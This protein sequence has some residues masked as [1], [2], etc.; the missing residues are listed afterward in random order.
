MCRLIHTKFSSTSI[1][2]NLLDIILSQVGNVLRPVRRRKTLVARV[3]GTS[4]SFEPPI[5]GDN[6]VRRIRAEIVL[7]TCTR[8]NDVILLITQQPQAV[9]DWTEHEYLE[10]KGITA[11]GN[12][13]TIFRNRGRVEVSAI[14]VVLA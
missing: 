1:F 10:V 7:G 13:H 2:I 12:E 4:N 8:L 3:P 5:V 6:R 14:H 11:I 9:H